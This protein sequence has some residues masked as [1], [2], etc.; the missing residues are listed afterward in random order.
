MESG[1]PSTE[2][3]TLDVQV[4]LGDGDC[5]RT[6]RPDPFV[7]VSMADGVC[8]DC[9]HA[10]DAHLVGLGCLEVTGWEEMA[11]QSAEGQLTLP[12]FVKG[13]G[14]EQPIP[15]S[16]TRGIEGIENEKTEAEDAEV[17]G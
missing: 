16:C 15:C 8:P 4:D 3:N 5:H 9:G 12:L 14:P 17:Y 2:Q 1:A 10:Q 6:G 7:E 11:E 13:S